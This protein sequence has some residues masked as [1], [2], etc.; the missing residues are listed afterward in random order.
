MGLGRAEISIGVSPEDVW[1]VVS[2]F[3][4]IDK[5]MPGVESCRLEGED[6]VLGMLGMEVV[7]KLYNSDASKRELVYGIVGGS[8][9]V[10]SHRA[11]ITVARVP[12]T[13]GG[14]SRVV[15]EVEVEPEDMVPVM[16]QV[17]GQS[18]E[19]LRHHLEP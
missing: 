5:W 4:G 18:L 9:P 7:E 10:D 6:R 17:Y 8:V 19:A 1:A 15:W 13:G 16:E 12:E 11:T 2:D 14:G 3:G